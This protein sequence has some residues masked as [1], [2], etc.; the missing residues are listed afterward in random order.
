[1]GRNFNISNHVSSPASGF[2]ASQPLVRVAWFLLYLIPLPVTVPKQ[3]QKQRRV[4]DSDAIPYS[5]LNE[6]T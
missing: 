1:M 3:G 6:D 5:V 4:R 2:D